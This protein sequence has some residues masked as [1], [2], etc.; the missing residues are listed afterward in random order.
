MQ[1]G[2]PR[3]SELD[4]SNASRLIS[5]Q[6]AP[7]VVYSYYSTL[8]FIRHPQERRIKL[9]GTE[10]QAPSPKQDSLEIENKVETIKDFGI[11]CQFWM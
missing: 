6:S 3:Q 9:G 8:A 1:S 11:V 7:I 4:K 10:I 2:K 5:E